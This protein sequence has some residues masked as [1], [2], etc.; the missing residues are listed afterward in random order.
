[1]IK[2]SSNHISIKKIKNNI[3]SNNNNNLDITS[4]IILMKLSII[5]SPLTINKIIHSKI[6]ILHQIINNQKIKF[7]PN[8]NQIFKIK[9]MMS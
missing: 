1:M 2:I 8:N 9:I 4:Q 7:K 6:Q 5:Y 3:K